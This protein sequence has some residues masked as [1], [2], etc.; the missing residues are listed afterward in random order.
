MSS[1]VGLE[2]VLRGRA[3]ASKRG[4]GEPFRLLLLGDFGGRARESSSDDRELA[5]PLKVDAVDFERAFT[6]FEPELAVVSPAGV[7]ERLS[8]G[9]V[10]DLHPDR[11][12]A[13]L[14]L[15]AAAR[16]LRGALAASSS[17]AVFERARSWL[18]EQGAAG[19]LAAGPQPASSSGGE[20]PETTLDR[21][22]GGSRGPTPDAPGMAAP[23]SAQALIERAVRP[24]V[25]PDVSAEKGPLLAEV[26]RVIGEQ[27]RRILRTPEYR[28]LEA[29]WR[30]A[31]RV[32]RSLDSD[33]ELEVWLLDVTSR[34]LAA[35]FAEA[36]A[37]LEA[38]RVHARLV[39]GDRHFT[40]VACDLSFG[41]SDE[42]LTLLAQLAATVA[43]ASGILLADAAPS[44]LGAGSVASAADVKSW[45]Q[46][47]LPAL[48]QA[49]RTSPLA[50][51]IGLVFP[52]VLA[53]RPYGKKREP[54]EGF[55]FEEL[56]SNAAF[57]AGERV[58][59]SGAF[60]AA[61]LLGKRFRE[62][63][64]D[65]DQGP[66]ELDDLPLDTFEDADGERKMVPCAE[67]LVPES[68]LAAFLE[69]GV[70]PLLA[71]RDRASVR[72]PQLIAFSAPSESLVLAA[73]REE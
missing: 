9:S 43:R 19:A 37:E 11:L 38:S 66:L 2:F 44:L 62:E 8:L 27:M 13:K 57:D 40:V 6:R 34:K 4:P 16:E 39:S 70:T 45:N 26:D 21:L 41:A 17:S 7:T 58:W 33:E 56:A 46:A 50:P 31:E 14:E 69:R 15:F 65:A 5:A 47:P 59:C 67:V 12:F 10:E 51:R 23:S 36:G 3:A 71:R 32:A 63:G 28:E 30:G 18:R 61:E 25:A 68:A 72:L 35:A 49:L 54:V 29:T 20:A 52:R 60:A 42:E 48:G 55:A 64:W 22:L 53:R 73:A 24:H 1:G